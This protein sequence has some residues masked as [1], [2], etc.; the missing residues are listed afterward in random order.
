MEHHEIIKKFRIVRGMTQK[1][2]AEKLGMT[3]SGYSKYERGERKMDVLKYVE[4]CSILKAPYDLGV[5]DDQLIFEN[6][7]LDFYLQL[8]K[9]VDS[10]HDR[11]KVMTIVE[12]KVARE[13][14]ETTF[15]NIK[16]LKEKIIKELEKV[17]SLSVEINRFGL[18]SLYDE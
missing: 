9:V 12:R 1:E 5:M 10:F 8:E 15:N 7:S 11:L 4:I 14:F 6:Y 2:V 13:L 17:S 16:D 3:H 18:Q